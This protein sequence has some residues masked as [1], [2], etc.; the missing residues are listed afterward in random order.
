MRP[1]VIFLELTYFQ[2]IGGNTVEALDILVPLYHN[3]NSGGVTACSNEGTI[4]FIK[5]LFSRILLNKCMSDN[6]LLANYA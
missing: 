2:G 6:I 1:K 5:L 3:F 4:E